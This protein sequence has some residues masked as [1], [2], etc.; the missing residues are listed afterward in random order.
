MLFHMNIDHIAR[1]SFSQP[2]MEA[3]GLLGYPSAYLSTSLMGCLPLLSLPAARSHSSATL[4]RIPFLLCADN[5]YL[6]LL[7]TSKPHL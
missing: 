2:D 7:V 3:L 4:H 1:E 6:V 5:Y